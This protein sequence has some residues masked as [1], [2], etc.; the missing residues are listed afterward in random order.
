MPYSIKINVRYTDN[1][2]GNRYLLP[3]IYTEQGILISHLRYLAHFN[4]R[5]QSW[6]TRSVFAIRLLLQFFS[7]NS[8]D[9][10][11]ATDLLR[12]FSYA[13]TTGTINY[14]TMDDQSDL[15]WLPRSP[16][17]ANTLLSHITRYTDF[18]ALQPEYEAERVNPFRKATKYEERLNWCAYYHKKSNVFLSHLKNTDAQRLKALSVRTIQG[19]EYLPLDVEQV[20]QFPESHIQTLLDNGFLINGQVDY[21]CQAISMLMNYGGLR[22]SEVFHLYIS[23]IQPHPVHHG[24]ALVRVFHPQYGE[25]PDPD[26]QDRQQ[27]LSITTSYK[28]RNTYLQTKLLFSG[29]K[30]SVL[31]DRR[32]FFEITFIPPRMA[33]EFL[34][35]WIKYLKYQRVEPPIN[36][37]HPFAFTCSQGQPETIKNFSRKHKRAVE[38]IGLVSRKGYG[39]TEHGHRHAYGYRARKHGLSLIEIQRLM[40]HKSPLSCLVYIRPTIED[41]R[42]ILRG[43]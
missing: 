26:Y 32:N 37:P 9:T 41:V 20:M 33:K 16:D 13:L 34:N 4:T 21:K 29:W 19:V 40:R 27:F 35:V 10:T 25:S 18:L 38:R 7:S 5:S 28:S 24:E 31:T 3:G 1:E 2:T 15:F 30:G 23:D 43:M 6:K 22:K 42:N 36:N 17:D 39:T 14:E 8:T 12:Q 11:K